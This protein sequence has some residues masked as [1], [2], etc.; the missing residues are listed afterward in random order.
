MSKP[1]EILSDGILVAEE[2]F[3]LRLR[4]RASSS[5]TIQIPDDVLASLQKIADSREMSVESLIKFY[6]GQGLRQDSL[7]QFGERTLEKAA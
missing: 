2:G 6:V 3:E 1:E 5:L 4:P 7:E